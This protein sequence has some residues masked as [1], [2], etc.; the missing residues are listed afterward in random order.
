[1]TPNKLADLINHN[2]TVASDL[3]LCMTQTSRLDEYYQALMDVK[4]T[5]NS[6]EVFSR[7]CKGVEL[8][9]EVI[10]VFVVKQMEMCRNEQHKMT[11]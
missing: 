6:L 2:M 4:T 11:Q 10:D 3:I 1:M 8:P 7:V 5:S 9:H